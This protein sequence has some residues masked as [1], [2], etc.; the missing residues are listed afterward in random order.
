MAPATHIASPSRAIGSDPPLIASR[1]WERL[2]FAPYRPRLPGGFYDGEKAVYNGPSGTLEDGS[3]VTKGQACVVVGR[4]KDYKLRKSFISV[5]FDTLIAG[6]TA[7]CYVD[8]LDTPL[9]HVG[10]GP[11]TLEPKPDG[12]EFYHFERRLNNHG[13]ASIHQANCEINDEVIAGRLRRWS[14]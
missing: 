8:C 6:K 7:K 12:S 4:P 13:F 2:G 10:I 3:S 1:F 11:L 5:H 14:I 9:H